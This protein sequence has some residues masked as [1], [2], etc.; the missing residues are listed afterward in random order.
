MQVVQV[1]PGDPV[2][3]YRKFSIRARSLWPLHHGCRWGPGDLT[4]QCA[5]GGAHLA[6]DPWCACGFWSC[7]RPDSLEMPPYGVMAV[8]ENWGTICYGMLDCL[9][10]RHS[11][12]VAVTASWPDRVALRRQY[13]Q[14]RLYRWVADMMDAYPPE[15]KIGR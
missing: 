6:P 2:R 11:R 1:P 14:A 15:G 10:A 8:T 7:T 3:G 12:I 9:R 4:A 5:A 13:P